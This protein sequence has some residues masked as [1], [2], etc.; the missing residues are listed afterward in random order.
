MKVYFP[1]VL[2]VQALTVWQQEQQLL[3]LEAITT[4]SPDPISPCPSMSMYRV[5]QTKLCGLQ[6]TSPG[7][8]S[9]WVI[10]YVMAELT[11]TQNCTV[12]SVLL[13]Q[14]PTFPLGESK[15]AHLSAR[16]CSCALPGPMLAVPTQLDTICVGQSET[17]YL[18]VQRNWQGCFFGVCV[19][20]A[21]ML[22]D[23]A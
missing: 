20:K 14:L 1:G 4:S 6:P 8:S 12:K 10:F 21:M 3:L 18:Q 23:N 16:P 15:D 22:D 19:C 2:L 9:N 17:V 11:I 13:P 7:A 5:L